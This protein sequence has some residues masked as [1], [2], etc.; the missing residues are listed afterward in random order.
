MKA[1]CLYLLLALCLSSVDAAVQLPAHEAQG[2]PMRRA[3]PLA[4]FRQTKNAGFVMTRDHGKKDNIHPADKK[5][6][7]VRCAWESWPQVSLFNEHDLPAS[8]FRT[9]N[10]SN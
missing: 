2:W 6:V 3:S 7:A 1:C 9:D 8:P 10:W 4:M 5:P